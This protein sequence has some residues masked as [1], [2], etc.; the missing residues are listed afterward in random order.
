MSCILDFVSP[1]EGEEDR[2]AVVELHLEQPAEP[3]RT[4]SGKRK[5]E[6][7][8][9]V[10]PV[11]SLLLNAFSPKWRCVNTFKGADWVS[12]VLGV[13]PADRIHMCTANRTHRACRS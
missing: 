5:K 13:W 11:S 9:R 4:R 1:P 7:P 8:L 3:L 10:L 2:D 6:E 12:N